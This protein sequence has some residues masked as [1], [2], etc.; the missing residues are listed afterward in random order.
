G[1]GLGEMTFVNSGS[2]YIIDHTGV[3]DAARGLGLGKKLVAVFVEHARSNDMKVL[4]LCPFAKAE[5][6]KNEAYGDILYGN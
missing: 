3:S 6:L 2:F 4:P 1:V 5:F